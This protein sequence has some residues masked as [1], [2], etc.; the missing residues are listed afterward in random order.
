[1]A[2]SSFHL[3][4]AVTGA[5]WFFRSL[6]SCL[7]LSRI[8][9]LG[10]PPAHGVRP[11]VGVVLVLRPDAEDLAGHTL[12][13]ICESWLRQV[14]VDVELVLVADRPGPELEA[15]LARFAEAAGCGDADSLRQVRVERVDA[16]VDRLPARH[17]LRD[18][19]T[20]LAC[21]WLLLCEELVVPGDPSTIARAVADADRDRSRSLLLVPAEARRPAPVL[22][23]SAWVD[24]I[25]E[26]AALASGQR[27]E[28]LQVRR[29]P[30][31][32][33]NETWRAGNPDGPAERLDPLAD[34]HLDATLH[35]RGER[36]AA[37]HAT[38]EL[39]RLRAYTSRDAIELLLRILAAI[40]YRIPLAAFAVLLTEVAFWIAIA[41]AF[42]GND[43]GLLAVVGLASQVIPATLIARIHRAPLWAALASP[44]SQPY[45]TLLGLWSLWI[46]GRRGRIRYD[47]QEFEIEDLK[48]AAAMRDDGA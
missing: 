28:A 44:L 35:A 6:R 23:L 20:H 19:A 33:R 22:A 39:T 30:R 8:P 24:G 34:S 4:F 16:R 45:G 13:G 21:D 27:S 47:G 32:I 43:W 12:A 41:G 25:P 31:L 3:T 36:I 37:V 1:M 5:F 7:A 29:C 2:E 11:W 46:A 40:G 15:E 26:L 42:S 18:G 9:F 10:P 48:R 17:A 38:D 14:G